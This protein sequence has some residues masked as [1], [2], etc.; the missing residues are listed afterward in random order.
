VDHAGDAG[1]VVALLDDLDCVVYADPDRLVSAVGELV[2]ALPPAEWPPVAQAILLAGRHLSG[3]PPEQRAWMLALAVAHLGLP[4]EARV[5]ALSRSPC[6]VVG[7]QHLGAPQQR[8]IGHVGPVWSVAV[9]R[10]GERDVIVTGGADS[11]ARIWD[12]AGRPI[13]TLR[14][15]AGTVRSVALGRWG[16]REVVVTAC[17]DHI[18]RV[19]DHNGEPM[20][21]LTSHAGPVCS[22]AVGRLGE[23]D[24]I[25]TGGADDGAEAWDEHGKVLHA[26]RG[27]T[28]AVWS[29]AVGGLGARDVIMTGSADGTARVWDDRG[30][31]VQVLHIADSAIAVRS[32]AIGRVGDQDFLVAGAAGVQVWDSDWT[33]IIHHA[34]VQPVSSAALGGLNGQGV[35]ISASDETLR[36]WTMNRPGA[37]FRALGV[38]PSGQARATHAVALGTLKDDDMIV[39]GGDSGA[40]ITWLS[41]TD[42]LQLSASGTEFWEQELMPTLEEAFFSRV[43]ESIF[44]KSS[45]GWLARRLPVAPILN[46]IPPPRHV[47][48]I[49]SITVGRLGRRRVVVTGAGRF[50]HVWNQSGHHEFAIAAAGRPLHFAAVVPRSWRQTILIVSGNGPEYGYSLFRSPQHR[51]SLKASDVQCVAIG[52]LGRRFIVVTGH[53]NSTAHIWIG[54]RKPKSTLTGHTGAVRSAAIGDLAGHHVI[55]TGSDDGTVR[56]WTRV[57]QCLAT[58]AGPGGSV[59]SLAIGWLGRHQ[60]VVAGGESGR[61]RIWWSTDLE[62]SG[63]SHGPTPAWGS[64]VP[65]VTLAGHTQPIVSVA[66]GTLSGHDYI[67]TASSDDTVQVWDDAGQPVGARMTLLSAVGPMAITDDHLI[68]ASGVALVT[69]RLDGAGAAHPTPGGLAPHPPPQ[70]SP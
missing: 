20:A 38:R 16:E 33:P 4:R 9:G 42:T 66:I 47:A 39:T 36:G 49:R 14:G 1:Q 45:L 19:W 56:L 12:D 13:A 28:R 64:S 52:W 32:V 10:L 43:V 6:A 18:A 41:P 70:V 48:P 7:A 30:R 40:V 69:L 68:V 60:V 25:V 24:V 8:L 3:H 29:V 34:H 22:V 21:M 65:S 54:I 67:A 50:A 51:L 58:L 26:L 37:R 15:H 5:E 17:D 11:T 46:R 59:R 62:D 57:G 53:S 55:A 44:D 27:H 2:G 35:L 31:L 61:A 63:R 23:R